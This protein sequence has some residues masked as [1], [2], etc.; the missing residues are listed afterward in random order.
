MAAVGMPGRKAIS[1]GVIGVKMRKPVA[2]RKAKVTLR[3]LACGG[4]KAWRSVTSKKRNLGVG[5]AHNADQRLYAALLRIALAFAGR[6]M[7]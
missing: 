4:V 6:A 2:R 7:P 5:V 1:G 3:C